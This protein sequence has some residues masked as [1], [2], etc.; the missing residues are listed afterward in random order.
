MSSLRA[1]VGT[2][3]PLVGLVGLVSLVVYLLHGFDKTL[4]RDL[5]V[6][7]YGGQRFLAGDPPYVGILNRAGPLAHI[8][9]GVGI[10]LGRVVGVS[11]IHA[12]RAFFTL[13]SV[14]CVCLVYLLVRDMFGSR[15]A[16]LV[17][18]AAFLGFQGFLDLATNGPREKTAMVLFLLAAL[19]AMQHR[20]W[21]TAGAFTALST[22]TW[23]PVFPVLLLAAIVAIVLVPEG[24]LGAM[25]RFAVGGA[26]PTAVTLVYYAVEGALHTFFEGFLLINAKYTQQG[27]ALSHLSLSWSTLRGGYG[28][29]LWVILVGLVALPVLAVLAVR[30]AW[31]T[32]DAGRATVVATGVATLAGLGWAGI[33]FNGWPD[34]FELLPFAALGIGGLV[35]AVL[36]RLDVRAATAVAATL[37]LVGTAFATVTSLDTRGT[38][39]LRQRASVAAI[40]HAGPRGAT[41][42]S[43]EAPEALVMAHRRNPSAIQ[44]F[45]NGFTRYVDDTWPGGLKGYGRWID[46]QA[47]TYIVVAPTF[48][49]SWLT[50]VLSRDYQRVGTAP[51]FVWWVRTSVPPQVR[52]RIHLASRRAMTHG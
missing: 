44:M 5:G 28:A 45:T 14:A 17:A 25:V 33:A 36:A 50:S 18:A 48:K 10:A 11:D 46:H 37:A 38:G 40:L 52:R 41:M 34:L 26:V 24:R 42:V 4:G 16:G 21:A 22:L 2:A 13:L 29:S 31:R 39:L 8:L 30:P 3:D 15:G 51:G 19:L 43:V 35:A 27:N 23:Q 20:R 47:P 9:P 7:M 1:R 32:R 6:Y 49:G 12:A